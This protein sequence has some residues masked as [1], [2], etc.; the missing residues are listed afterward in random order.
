MNSTFESISIV[1]SMIELGHILGLSV[2]A[3]GVE[4]HAGWQALSV[5]GCDEVQGYLIAKPMLASDLESWLAT[6]LTELGLEAL[7]NMGGKK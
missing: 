4:T 3:E 2:V 5:M 6:D 1:R 7:P